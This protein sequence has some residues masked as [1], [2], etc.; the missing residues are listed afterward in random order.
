MCSHCRIP[1]HTKDKCYKLN[2]LSPGHRNNSRFKSYA[3]QS[4][5][6]QKQIGNGPPLT[7]GQYNQLLAL[8]QPSKSPAITPAA[9]HVR[10]SSSASEISPVSGIIS[11]NFTNTSHTITKPY[12]S[13]IIN[14]EAT[15]HMI[16][17]PHLFTHN[18]SLVSHTIK[19]L[20]GTTTNAT[21]VGDICLSDQFILKHVLCVPD[22]FC[23][24]HSPK[25]LTTHSN[26]CLIF[27]SKSC[28][29]QDLSS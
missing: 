23:N 11:C 9:N 6:E 12:C 18:V 1:G 29:I 3:N 2:G 7:Q 26:C 5:L 13:W 28:Y 21:H 4:S 15:D 17:R 19:L 14:T 25:S 8:L 22:F 24:L 10:S 20:N 27:Y 16:C